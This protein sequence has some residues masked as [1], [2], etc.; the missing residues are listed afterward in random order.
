M[1]VAKLWFNSQ[2]EVE[3]VETRRLDRIKSEF[4]KQ[5]RTMLQDSYLNETSFDELFGTLKEDALQEVCFISSCIVDSFT[6]A[7]RINLMLFHY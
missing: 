7:D 1:C 2:R 3:L 5:M 4:E 6:S